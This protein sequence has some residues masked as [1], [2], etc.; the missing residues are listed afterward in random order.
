[1]V[2]GRQRLYGLGFL[3]AI[4]GVVIVCLVVSANLRS[5][6]DKAEF[7]TQLRL[8]REEGIP[9]TWSEFA[10]TIRPAPASENA[11][12][13]HANFNDA[14]NSIDVPRDLADDVTFRFSQA[15][16]SKAK[17][18]LRR[19][20]KEIAAFDAAAKLPR[21]WFDRDWSKGMA[22]L[23]KEF[24]T[25]KAGARLL[26]LR[27]SVAA[28]EN[29]PKTALSN[30]HEMFRLAGHAGEEGTALSVLVRDA[31]WIL[32][33]R[34]LEAWS[35]VHRGEPSYALELK[36]AIDRWRHPDLLWMERD[37]LLAVL[38]LVDQSITPAG[39]RELGL[40]PGDESPMESASAL[41]FN[42]TRSR[43]EIVKAERRILASLVLPP[44]RRMA[45]IGAAETSR[46]DALQA[47]PTAADIYDKLVGDRHSEFLY[48][49]R[50][51]AFRKLHIA[52]WRALS[53]PSIP[54][55]LDTADLRSPFDGKSVEYSYTHGQ[56]TITE[57]CP[58]KEIEIK[59]LKI[60]AD[61]TTP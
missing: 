38:S 45:E 26:A 51:D 11:A 5:A 61:R 20:A 12:S 7:R 17:A 52:A 4:I 54:K 50:N 34:R 13:I 53:E 58:D 25:I 27:G 18:V 14:S 9:T 8:A 59:P 55:S 29:R 37:D 44:D 35:F 46:D 30:I 2:K 57:T 15:T 23:M 60:P 3:L 49:E 22:V 33:L 48:D 42:R 6:N 28:A 16:L 40:R 19:Y 47:F 43:A 1:M 24:P 56:I 10:A 32:A 39:R 21:C 36:N 31:I 41:L